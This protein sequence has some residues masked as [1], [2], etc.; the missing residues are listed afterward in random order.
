ALL[1]ILKA[2]AGYVPIDPKFPAARVQAIVEDAGV[3]AI[4]ADAALAQAIALPKGAAL[5]AL[6]E[7]GQ[8]ATPK[9]APRPVQIAPADV[10]YV[11]YTSGSTG[12]PKGVVVEHRNAVNFV[13]SLRTVYKLTPHERSE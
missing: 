4:F 10:C 13:Q 1:G 3:K 8:G 12:R 9:A 5:F 6:E 11:I 2:G 7:A